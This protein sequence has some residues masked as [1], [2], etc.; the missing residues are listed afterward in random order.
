M[1]LRSGVGGK[2]NNLT[3]NSCSTD[4]HFGHFYQFMMMIIIIGRLF[5]INVI[6]KVM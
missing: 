4:P 3:Q 6:K 5:H 1:T 2:F